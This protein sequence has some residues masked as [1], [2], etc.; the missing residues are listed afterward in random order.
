MT[1]W[2]NRF[3]RSRG[4]DIKKGLDWLENTYGRTDML[5]GKRSASLREPNLDLRRKLHRLKQEIQETRE[6]RMEVEIATAIARVANTALDKELTA[7]M[8]RYATLNEETVAMRKEHDPVVADQNELIVQLM[9]QIA[10][11][12]VEMQRRQD[13]PNPAFTTPADGRPPLHF[14]P[15]NAEQAHNPPSSPT[16]NPAAGPPLQTQNVNHPQTSLRH[17]NQHTNPQTFPQNYQATQNAQS[18]SIAPPLPQK[19]TFQIP[20]PN[21][22]DVNGSKLDHYEEREREWRSKE[23]TAKLDMKEEIRKAMKEL[24]CIPEVA[25]LN[26]EDLCIH[27]NLDL[28]EG[29]KVPKFDVFG[30]TGNPLAHLRAYCD[31]L[32]GVGRDEALLMRLFSRSL[33]GEALEWFTSHETRQ[34]PSWNALAKDFIERFAYNVEIVPDRYSL[35]KMK[36]KS[37]ESY[38]EFA[39]RWRKEAA[40][41]R[42]PMSEKEIVEVFVRVQEPEYYDRIMLLVG[43]KFAEIVKVGETIEDG[44]RT[45]KIARVAASPGSSGLLKKK[46]ED[47]SSISYEGKKAPRK[48]LSFQGRSRPLQSSYLACHAQADYQN[49]P[50]PSYHNTPPPSY[51]NTPPPSYQISPPIYQTP[52]PVYQTPP[53]HYQNVAPNCANPNYQTNSY[54]RYQASRPN[55]PN[56]R[57]MPPPQQGNHDPPRP[58]FEKKPARV[59]T[60]LVESRAKLFERLTAAGYI[61]PVGPKPVDT[62]SRFYRPDQRCAYHSNSVG[63]DTEDCINLKHKIQDLIDQKVVSSA[64]DSPNVNSNPLPNHGG[65][66]INMIETDDYW[67]VTKAIVP[68]APDNLERAVASLSIREKKEFVILTPEKVVALVPRE[69][70]D[71]PEF[72]IETAVT[73]GMTRS[74]RCYTRKTEEFWRKMQPKDYSIV[75]HLEKTPAQ[76]SVWALLMS[77]QMH[78]QALM[79]AL[80]DTYV[81]VGTNSDNLAAMI[82]QVIRGHRISF[83]D[84]ELPFEGKMHNRAMHVTCMC[85]DKIINRVLVDDGSGLNICPLSTLRQLKIDIGKLRQNQVNVRAFDRVQRDTLGAVNLDIQVGPADFNVEFQVL[86]INTSY[87]LLLGRPFIHMAGAVSSTLHQIMKFVWKNQELV[88]Y[89]EGSHSNRYAPIVDDVSQGCDFYT[90]ELVN[91]TGDDLAPQPPMPHVYKMIATVMLQSGFEP[92]FGLESTFEELSSLSRF[93]PR[94]K[95]GL[96][97]VP[98]DEVELQNKRVDR[99]WRANP[100]LYDAFRYKNML[101]VMVSGKESGTFLRRLMQLSRKKLGHQAS[102]MQNLESN[103]KIGSPHRS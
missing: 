39:Y 83:C 60:P 26:Y 50:L 90:V 102:V 51:Q 84:E 28:P 88:I 82:N 78:R 24:Q 89:G 44:L 65:V 6:R 63:H 42:P 37:N 16:H 67:C 86:D 48:S 45:R 92:C 21:E 34:W 27:P 49:I 3:S 85:R 71:R 95:F 41:V 80:D 2:N 9:Q 73:Q 10:E 59:F 68:I 22:H 94:A 18:P 103:C 31:Q 35:E 14:P 81:P 69:T 30:G 12:R 100:H 46:R 64:Y 47:V 4:S 54:P 96:G 11:M 43:A 98:D 76:I 29:F 17:Q 62:S 70:P 13:L 25:G 75:K 7:K 66:T 20:V 36:Q 19:T 91:A 23:E 53:H 97:Y 15:P 101:T 40:R 72:V 87:N 77:S 74:G 61:H 56:Y 1:V 99:A 5:C 38:R 57:Q 55:T 52:P 32:V 33:S 79:R 8:A 58:R 93:S